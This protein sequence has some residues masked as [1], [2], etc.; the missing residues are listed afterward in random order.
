MP[1]Q[2]LDPK[3]S[4]TASGPGPR[5][6]PPVRLSRILLIAIAIILTGLAIGFLPRWFTRRALA[7][8]TQ[9]LAATTVAIVSPSPGKSDFGVPLPAEVQAFVEAPIYSRA[10]GYLKR[11]LVDMGASVKA[12]QLLAE[13]ETPEVDQQ[14]AQAKAE[15]AQNRATLNLAKI[16]AARWTDLLKT[17]SVSEQE[18]AEKQSDLE[19]KKANLDAALANLHRLEELK[20]FASI[21]APFDGTITARQ[22]DVGQLITAGNGRELFRLA[23][24]NPLRV[25]VRVPQTMSRAVMPGQMAELI[26]DQFPGKKV[27][28]KVVRTAGAIEPGSRTLLTELAVDN[29]RGEILA[30]SYAQVRFIDSLAAPVLTLPANTLLFRAEGIR[31]G[32]VN[33]DNK[34]ELRVVIPGRDF[35]Q[36]LEILEG[37]AADDRVIMNPPD[38]LAA[39]LKVRVAEPIK[40]VPEK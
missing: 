13:I 8:T 31:V 22:T 7:Q 30:G 35:G 9:E 29:A 18:T 17:A 25:Y 34:V 40:T 6:T 2:S 36:T 27:A 38:S 24:V 10:S 16:T 20:T 4:A 26:L 19:L 14:L 11:W 39:G 1:M 23:Q 37:V 28:A 3:L 21:T 33:A 12:G 32:V 15:V 5:A